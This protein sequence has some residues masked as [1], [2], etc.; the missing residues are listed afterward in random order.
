MKPLLLKI[1][2]KK[3]NLITQILW[4]YKIPSEGDRIRCKDNLDNIVD[5]KVVLKV[6]DFTD[7]SI[8]LNT[9]YERD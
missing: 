8:I 2:D 6:Y 1:F 4:E 7:K 3:F 9:D 5:C